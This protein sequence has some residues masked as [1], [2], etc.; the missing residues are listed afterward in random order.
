[1]ERSYQPCSKDGITTSGDE[2]W[3]GANL[4]LS[5]GGH[6]GQLVPDDPS[7]QANAPAATE[8]SNCTWRIKGDDGTKVQF[9]TGAT[10]GTWNGSYIKVTDTS[11]T[12]Y[13]FGLNHLPDANGNPTTLGADSGSAWTLPVYSPNSGD[14]CYDPAKSQASWCQSAW[15]W[16]LDYVVDSHSNLTTYSYTPEANFYARG[17]GQNNGTGSNSSYTRG[18]VLASIGYGQLLSDQLN[19]NGGYQPAAKIVF[20]STER[21]VTSTAACDPRS[22][23]PRTRRT[24]LTSRST[25]SAHRA[26]TA[27]TTAPLSGPPSGWPRSPPRSRST[28]ATSRWTPTR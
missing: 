21:C 22:A 28:A 25:S 17:G 5:L 6:S 16:N 9:L 13:Y 2:C 23:R 18:G 7:C 8:Q 14:P 24:G 10:N 27:P 15:R 3:A 19:N 1:M 26:T 12:V 11:G 4:T 20:N